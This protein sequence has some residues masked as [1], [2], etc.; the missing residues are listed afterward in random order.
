MVGAVQALGVPG[1]SRWVVGWQGAGNGK[2]GGIGEQ[3]IGREF[4]DFF[5]I[6][7]P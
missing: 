3:G 6:S 5:L 4:F 1:A 2:Q 7:A